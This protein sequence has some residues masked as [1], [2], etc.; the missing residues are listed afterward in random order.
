MAI[1]LYSGL[2]Y[3]HSKT[4]PDSNGQLQYII[5]RDIK[6][7]NILVCS[8]IFVTNL[9]EPYSYQIILQKVTMNFQVK[10][11]DFGIAEAKDRS[12]TLISSNVRGTPL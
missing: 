6:P 3:L 2:A 12:M 5:H 1:G 4:I 7:Q 8:I 10:I 9:S 11:C